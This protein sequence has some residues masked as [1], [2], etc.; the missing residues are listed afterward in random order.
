MNATEG[1]QPVLVIKYGGST[2]GTTVRADDDVIR[3]IILLKQNGFQPL[4][5]HGGGKAITDLLGR[6]G[7]QARFVDGL[8]VTD[9]T[10]LTAVEMVLGGQVNKGLAAAFHAN[11][12][13]AVG[14]TG[15]DGGLLHV[16]RKELPAGDIG[17]VGEVEEVRPA[18][19]HALLGAGFLPVVA[20]LGVDARGQ[21]YNINADSAAG[22]IAGALGAKSL[23]LLTDVPGLMK[24]GAI[25]PQV[26]PEEITEMIADGTIHGGMIPKVEACLTALAHGA[27]QVRIVSGQD[28]HA[29]IHLLLE[30]QP[31]GTLVQGGDPRS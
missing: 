14:V 8:R 16:K 17:Y 12:C 20:P 26:T 23:I 18:L 30:Q 2:I 21:R 25:I 4:L 3:D 28:P 5:V 22:A 7:H 13:P 11:G 24:D 31:I 15:I 19:L 9:E 10:T 29:L 6:W 27:R 1:Q